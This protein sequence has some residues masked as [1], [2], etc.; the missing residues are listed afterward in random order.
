MKAYKVVRQYKNR[1]FSA[2]ASFCDIKALIRKEK[3]HFS[4][5]EYKLG[6][7]TA[8]S[9]NAPATNKDLFIFEDLDSATNYKTDDFDSVFECEVDKIKYKT[10]CS[11]QMID[12]IVPNSRFCRK[13]KLTKL[14]S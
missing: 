10:R 4:C 11:E 2:N 6:K 8:A 14:V 5:I 3:R 9:R 7:E 13:I 12:A 1:Y